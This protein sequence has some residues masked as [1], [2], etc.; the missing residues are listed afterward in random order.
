MMGVLEGTFNYFSAMDTAAGLLLSGKKPT[1]VVKQ[2]KEAYSI[3]DNDADQIYSWATDR[4]A[5]EFKIKLEK[6]RS[7]YYENKLS[8]NKIVE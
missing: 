4:A 5:V 6:E 8:K 7:V 3:S 2:I 1:E